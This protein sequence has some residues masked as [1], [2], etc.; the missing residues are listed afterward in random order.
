MQRFGQSTAKQFVQSLAKQRTRFYP[1]GMKS[2]IGIAWWPGW[3]R[4][5]DGGNVQ[6][7]KVNEVASPKVF[8]DP[9]YLRYEY[10]ERWVVTNPTPLIAEIIEYLK[11]VFRFDEQFGDLAEAYVFRDAIWDG[12]R[13]SGYPVE[14]QWNRATDGDF[15][16]SGAFNY[17]NQYNV[18]P[19][20]AN[21]PNA[22]HTMSPKLWMVSH[23]YSYEFAITSLAESNCVAEQTHS[24][25]GVGY[26]CRM[27][28]S[29]SAPLSRATVAVNSRTALEQLIMTRAAQTVNL[30]TDPAHEFYE[31]VPAQFADYVFGFNHQVEPVLQNSGLAVNG[32]IVAKC[33]HSVLPDNWHFTFGPSSLM[34]PAQYPAGAFGVFAIAGLR[35]SF[36]P[37]GGYYGFWYQVASLTDAIFSQ[38]SL[39]NLPDGLSCGNP[40]PTF[41][42]PYDFESIWMEPAAE[43]RPDPN[44]GGAVNPVPVVGAKNQPTGIALVSPA[45]AEIG[46]NVG[47]YLLGNSVLT[48]RIPT[49]YLYGDSWITIG[50]GGKANWRP[51]GCP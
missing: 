22:N 44:G 46:A 15:F 10:T 42:L 49:P 18:M 51:A 27:E 2:V 50:P 23:P 7:Y 41:G 5:A 43:Y 38:K 12:V 45:S 32:I 14:F 24:A 47:V 4:L 34:T 36:S 40:V 13:Q 17:F 35:A 28:I 37:G 29:L 16:A 21:W 39:V 1:E 30:S 25:F 9:K 48:T 8:C 11:V 20:Q 3:L 19:D 33:R 31:H 26:H 6:P